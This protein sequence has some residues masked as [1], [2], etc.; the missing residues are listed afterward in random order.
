MFDDGDPTIGGQMGEVRST[1]GRKIIDH[2]H[3]VPTGQQ[4]IGQVGSNEASPT[5]DEDAH[6]D[7]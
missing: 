7:Q 5:G 2:Y 3:L 6:G 1:P 4:V